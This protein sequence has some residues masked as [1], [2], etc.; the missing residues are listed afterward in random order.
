MSS[1]QRRNHAASY[2][3]K[4]KEYLASAEENLATG[5]YTPAAGDAIHA[6][7]SAKDAMVA[8]RTGATRKGKD[9]SSA[10]KELR[11]ALGKHSQSATAGKA[12]GEL[13]AAKRSVAYG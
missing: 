5:R 4:A 9:H 3:T 8:I 1:G 10:A 13:L 6:G 12:F 11:Q 2:L 7:I